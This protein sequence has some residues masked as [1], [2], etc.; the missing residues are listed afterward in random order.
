M[1]ERY[2]M[3]IDIQQRVK[4]VMERIDKIACKAA[5]N[6]DDITLIAVTKTVRE[7]MILE[8]INAGIK[9]IGESRVQEFRKKHNNIPKKIKRHFIGTLQ[10][11]KVKYIV[12]KVDLIH[13]LDRLSLAQEI[14]RRAL[15]I[16]KEMP[17][18]IQ[19]NVSREPTKSGLMEEELLQFIEKITLFKNIRVEGL[20]TIAPFSYDPE[21]VRQYFTR[22]RE[23]FH[24]VEKQNYPHVEMKYLSMGMTNDYEIAIQ[25]GAN[26]VRIGRAIFGER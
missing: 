11:N 24:E 20:M 1:G 23:L 5:R 6:P 22:L 7:D 25:E 15:A 21:D 4:N 8:A 2:T 16:E 17:V 14:N 10:T 13:S 9:N 3:N 26:M 18:L 19:V 12:D